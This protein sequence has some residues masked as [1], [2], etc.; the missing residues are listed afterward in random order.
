MLTERVNP[1]ERTVNVPKGTRVWVATY[2][3][4]W[5]GFWQKV[6][7]FVNPED[8]PK[9]LPQPS[10]ELDQLVSEIND[11]TLR[12]ELKNAIKEIRG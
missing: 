11:P 2:D 3:G 12:A 1:F 10:N 8:M 5:G 7:V 6:L 4:Q 9:A